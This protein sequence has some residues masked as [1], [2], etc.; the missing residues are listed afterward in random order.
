MKP[1]QRPKLHI[2][3][4]D[5]AKRQLDTAIRMF[6]TN[7]DPVSIH[8]LASAGRGILLD[9]AE[10][11]GRLTGIASGLKELVREEMWP[12]A[13]RILR[14][15]QNF[16]KHANRDAEGLLEFPTGVT[17]VFIW[18]GVV[19]YESL[20]GERVALFMV[21]RGWFS[22]NYPEF[23]KSSEHRSA[24]QSIPGLDPKNRRQFL[25]LLPYFEEALATGA[26]S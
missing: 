14:G 6:L 8:T 20:T 17:E 12:E 21:F 19:H 11:Q 4:L 1:S 24:L 23:L 16:F 22:L 25:E 13:Q 2:S 10:G 7:G 5:A 9:L 15:P 3:K 26:V 18:D